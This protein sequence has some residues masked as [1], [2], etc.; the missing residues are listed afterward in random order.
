MLDWLNHED[1]LLDVEHIPTPVG[2]PV[3]ISVTDWP[4]LSNPSIHPNW[5]EVAQLV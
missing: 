1:L 5:A 4:T 2:P 3:A